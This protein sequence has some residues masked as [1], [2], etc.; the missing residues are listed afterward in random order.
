[1]KLIIF[2]L[3]LT[4]IFFAFG[5]ELI[6]VAQLDQLFGDGYK[7]VEIEGLL[8]YSNFHTGNNI[9]TEGYHAK[10][11]SYN[12]LKTDLEGYAFKNSALVIYAEGK[13]SKF[14][15]LIP[16][17]NVAKVRVCGKFES[18]R[19]KTLGDL[20]SWNHQITIEEYELLERPVPFT[21]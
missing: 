12:V 18:E 19:G 13:E 6:K 21:F 7:K 1:M 2:L 5:K 17:R 4:A 14:D 20:G 9:C 16:N 15:S 3:I 11:S 8:S 10:S